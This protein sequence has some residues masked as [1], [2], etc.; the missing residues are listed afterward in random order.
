MKC[1]NWLPC[2]NGFLGLQTAAPSW[3]GV[4]TAPQ[5][6]NGSKLTSQIVIWVC[7]HTPAT[8][9]I[10]YS[11]ERGGTLLRSGLHRVGYEEASS[12]TSRIVCVL[13]AQRENNLILCCNLSFCKHIGLALCMCYIYLLSSSICRVCVVSISNSIWE[14]NHSFKRFLFTSFS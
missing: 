8:L 11:C 10:I 5:Y 4:A 3:T 1:V 12:F 13:F 7:Q 9:E 6:N 2:F 14:R